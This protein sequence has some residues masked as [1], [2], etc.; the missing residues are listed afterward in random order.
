M[1]DP[2]ATE[3]RQF[4]DSVRCFCEKHNP[5]TSVVD[6]VRMTRAAFDHLAPCFDE[7]ADFIPD[8]TTTVYLEPQTRAVAYFI[9][10]EA[11]PFG[12]TWERDE[13]AFET[14]AEMLAKFVVDCAVL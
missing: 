7:A 14:E 4:K 6:V 9:P 12:Y 2:N 1:R 10:G 5:T 8:G 13:Y 3:L 11:L